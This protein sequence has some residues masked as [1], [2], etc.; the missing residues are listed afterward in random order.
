[1]PQTDYSIDFEDPEASIDVGDTIRC[2]YY[3]R[4]FIQRRI[5][6][7]RDARLPPTLQYFHE[8]VGFD[9]SLT[10]AP[11]RPVILYSDALAVLD[12]FA[13]KMQLEGYHERFAAVIVTEGEEEV[14]EVI[15]S[16]VDQSRIAADQG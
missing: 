4:Q 15:I 3:A 5:R 13:R 7:F 14:A 11:T 6:H 1:M 2:I 12:A 8:S 9:I 10:E 16:S